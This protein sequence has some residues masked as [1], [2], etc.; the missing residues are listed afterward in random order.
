MHMG[1]KYVLY[2]PAINADVQQVNVAMV[3]KIYMLVT[4]WDF[5]R[6]I[7][8]CWVSLNLS[9]CKDK[10]L[11]W[12]LLAISTVPASVS[13]YSFYITAF[14]SIIKKADVQ[15]VSSRKRKTRSLCILPCSFAA[16]IAKKG[17]KWIGVN[18]FSFVK[19]KNCYF[20]APFL[21]MGYL[22]FK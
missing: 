18:S 15:K 7:L 1:V 20:F 16:V 19:P 3:S 4:E 13:A 22:I 11:L 17:D 6:N 8:Y 2:L 5:Q 14:G 12:F 10:C 9:H 21:L